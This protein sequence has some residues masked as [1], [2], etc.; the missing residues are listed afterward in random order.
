M[1]A[2]PSVTLSEVV[3]LALPPGSRVLT[4]E[5]GLGRRVH[6]ARL[7]RAR[8]TSL[9]S[10]EPG[11]LLILSPNVLETMTAHGVRS[12]LV[13]DLIE[14]GAAALVVS[15]EP[16]QTVL[17]VCQHHTTP[18]LQVPAGTQLVELERSIIQ[19]ILDR[20]AQLRRRVEEIYN[21]LL[22]T[23]LGGAG[24]DDLLAA[25]AE[26]TRLR[27]AVFDDYP[28]LLALAPEDESFKQALAVSAAHVLALES[29]PTRAGR[30]VTL[31][32]AAGD[33]RWTGQLYPLRIGSAWAGYL[34][35]FGSPDQIGELDRLLAERAATLVALELAKQRAVA[36]ATLRWRG[37]FLDDL[38]DGTF[39]SEEAVLSRARQLGYDLLAPHVPCQLAVDPLGDGE[40]REVAA[41]A[42]HRRRFVEVAR[43]LL[44]RFEPRS[45]AVER[46]GALAALIPVGRREEVRQRLEQLR[47]AVQTALPGLSVSAGVGPETRH[48]SGVAPAWRLAQQALVIGQ[49]LLGGGRVV[50]Y[51]ELGVE[52]LL[53]HLI[54]HP[55]LA[56]F[57]RDVL[58][59]LLEHDAARHGELVRTLEVFLSCNGNHVHAA[60]ELHLHRNTL[61]YRLERIREILGRDLEDAETR[62]ALQVALRIRGTVLRDVTASSVSRVARRRRRA[63]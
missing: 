18:L 19:L 54:G 14:A 27:A 50:V 44:L 32:F 34:G 24:L 36:E 16:H 12:H 49:R 45:L 4:G 5:Q 58:G 9:S 43:A 11:E 51:T 1:E 47:V 22:A 37:E 39:P 42:R 28:A 62:L 48:P 25:L 8:P 17:Q 3:L 31:S 55:E 56:Q 29:G 33:A 41:A 60:R 21:R 53:V 2:L 26:A 46:D 52:R 13:G 30:P 35:L 61:L 59:P 20:E 7:L 63:G 40:A 38:L 6:W 15:G 57:V 10:L 23:M